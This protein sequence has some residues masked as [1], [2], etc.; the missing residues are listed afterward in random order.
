MTVSSHET[1]TNPDPDQKEPRQPTS[2]ADQLTNIIEILNSAQSLAPKQVAPWEAGTLQKLDKLHPQISYLLTELMLL[3]TES[4]V[5]KATIDLMRQT[6]HELV[7]SPNYWQ[8]YQKLSELNRLKRANNDRSPKLNQAFDQI[9]GGSNY[10]F[11]TITDLDHKF[12]KSESA[13][14]SRARWEQLLDRHYFWRE[15]L[16]AFPDPSSLS[17]ADLRQLRQ[18]E[19]KS[20]SD[21]MTYLTQN[22][23]EIPDEN[24]DTTLNALEI[25]RKDYQDIHR[26]DNPGHKDRVDLI[27]AAWNA[28]RKRIF[29]SLANHPDNLNAV[30]RVV[31]NVEEGFFEFKD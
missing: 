2:L 30:N 4:E 27:K 6:S 19:Q 13:D 23:E 12:S 18:E 28:I 21:F 7:N 26:R 15:V 8:A 3:A 11:N 31:A 14:S 24:L 20:F 1:I 9:S 10:L 5:N 25:I 29:K 17:E 22:S 16:F